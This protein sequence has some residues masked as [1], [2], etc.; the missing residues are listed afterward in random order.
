MFLLIGR[1]N[2]EILAIRDAYKS[3]FGGAGLETKFGAEYNGPLKYLFQQLLHGERDE[4]YLVHKDV[5]GDARLL[6]KAVH[7]N[8]LTQDYKEICHVLSTRDYK[9][10]YEVFDRHR[11][12]FALET[13]QIVMRLSNDSY[14]SKA[15]DHITSLIISR[16][17]Y[18][19]QQ[20]RK[21][22]QWKS[23]VLGFF[24]VLQVDHERLALWLV[25][26]RKSPLLEGM[27]GFAGY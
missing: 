9:H 7:G 10:L 25:R 27:Q 17:L 11:E 2:A 16:E 1:T 24:G 22:V 6:H 14:S 18:F 20:F 15:Q 8:L 3:H 5:D 26:H 12:L 13:I 19:G 23:G 21:F 4:K